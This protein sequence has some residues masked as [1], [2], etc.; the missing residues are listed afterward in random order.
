[1]QPSTYAILTCVVAILAGIVVPRIWH[2]P[3]A[4]QPKS[5]SIRTC[6]RT[7]IFLLHYAS[8]DCIPVKNWP[9]NLTEVELSRTP[10]VI[11]DS[12][13]KE[14]KALKSWKSYEYL[15]RHIPLLTNVLVSDSRIF[16]YFDAK[17]RKR[18]AEVFP[19]IVK[20]R[21]AHVAAMN[22]TASEFLR[23]VSAPVQAENWLYYSHYFGFKTSKDVQRDGEFGRVANDLDLEFLVQDLDVTT[24]KANVWSA[25]AGVITNTHYDGANNYFV[26]VVGTKTFVLSPPRSF[27]RM[28]LFPHGHPSDR[29]SQVNP[30]SRR[31]S[32]LIRVFS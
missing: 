10:V 18:W 14:M 15:S 16:S 20:E 4:F 8:V 29:Q 21:A 32:C 3:F 26:Q 5:V 6:N 30:L 22:M 12:P 9:V 28:H 11:R 27:E 17:K 13:A 19:G 23:N 25:A 7:Q 24:V 1:M 31:C 2:Y